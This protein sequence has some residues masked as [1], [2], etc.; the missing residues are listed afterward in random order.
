MKGWGCLLQ[1]RPPRGRTPYALL[2]LIAL[3]RLAPASYGPEHLGLITLK[4][5]LMSEDAYYLL[6]MKRALLRTD[7]ELFGNRARYEERSRQLAGRLLS[8]QPVRHAL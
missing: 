2:D 1:G 6:L 7:A 8:T 3:Q 4:E 5:D